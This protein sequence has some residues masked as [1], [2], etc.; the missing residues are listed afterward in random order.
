M[1]SRIIPT[2]R[3]KDVPAAIEFLCNA[4]GFERSLVVPG[5]Q[6]G[7]GAT[8]QLVFKS[9]T[10]TDMIMLGTLRDE[11]FVSV[12][13]IPKDIGGANTQSAYIIV[14]EIDAHYEHARANGAEIVNDIRDQH[15]GGRGYTC[16]DPEGYIW[17]FG[18]YDPWKADH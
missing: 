12:V 2:M 7:E 10:A 6:E 14:D 9:G 4:L 15:Y 8:A 16:R 13:K 3:Y 5:E 1:S 18:S 17:N 11:E